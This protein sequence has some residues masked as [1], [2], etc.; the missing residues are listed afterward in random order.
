MSSDEN[1]KM[2]IDLLE[3]EVIFDEFFTVKRASL[4]HEKF[5]GSM[6]EELRRYSFEKND[7]VAA[8]IYHREKDAVLL[9][10]QHRYPPMKHGLGWLVEVVAGGVNEGESP[11]QAI[12]REIEEEAGYRVQ[13]CT[14]IHDMYVSPGV[15]SERIKLYMAEVS[16]EDRINGGGGAD[17]EDED[18]EL[19]WIRGEDVEG[20]LAR[21]RVLDAKTIVALYHFLHQFRNKT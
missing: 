10:R 19:V 1:R 7:A 3:E 20:W 11:D 17:D 2:R 14:P 9:V 18:I 8:L 5:D 12:R 15:F 4:R 16:G 13:A 6:S 21:N